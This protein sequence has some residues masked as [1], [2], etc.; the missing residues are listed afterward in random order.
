MHRIHHSAA[1]PETDSNFGVAFS[2]WDRVFGTYR[3]EPRDG[4]ASMT[5]GLVEF[6]DAKYQTLPWM[7]VLP[8]LAGR[9]GA[10]HPGRR[11]RRATASRNGLRRRRLPGAAHSRFANGQRRGRGDQDPA[12][13]Q[14]NE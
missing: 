11:H 10:R 6:R 5:V 4:H 13:E 3:P 1:Q 7:L 2:L 14:R 9:A 8:F 12:G